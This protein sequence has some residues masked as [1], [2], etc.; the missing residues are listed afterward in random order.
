MSSNWGYARD[1]ED[2]LF[3]RD[4]VTKILDPVFK[5]PGKEKF[6]FV[7]E[8]GADACGPFETYEAA[9]EAAIQYGKTI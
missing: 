1:R 3:R 9:R 2:L 5:I 8:T 4:P 7:D 6:G